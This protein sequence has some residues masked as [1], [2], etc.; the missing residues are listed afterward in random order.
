[1]ALSNIELLLECEAC[2]IDAIGIKWYEEVAMHLLGKET[3]M[4]YKTCI[5][6]CSLASNGLTLNLTEICFLLDTKITI[7]IS[8]FCV[9]KSMQH[10]LACISL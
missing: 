9:L 2:F 1:M 3:L 8:M 5:H 6:L 7:C 10:V 4:C